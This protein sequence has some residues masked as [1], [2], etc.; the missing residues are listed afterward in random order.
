MVAQGFNQ[1]PSLDYQETFSPVE[2]MPTVRVFIIVALHNSWPIAQ[3]DISNAFLH[4]H[5]TER[6]YMKQPPGFVDSVYPDHVCSLK[7]AIYGLKQSPRQWYATL[8]SHL[9]LFDFQFSAADPSL[10][11]YHSGSTILYILIYVDDILLTGNDQATLDSL[12]TSLKSKFSMRH[13]DCLSQFLGVHVTASSYGIHLN[14]TQY[15]WTIL[16]KAGMDNSKSVSTPSRPKSVA[17]ST[18]Q[19]HF[20]DP[21]LYRQLAGSL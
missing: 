20:S 10:M 21:F 2:K 7:K 12:L 14:Q 17:D 5:L 1:A 8:S 19:P 11:V 13:L 4:G 6:V 15:A 16:H 18:N 3:L 9:Q